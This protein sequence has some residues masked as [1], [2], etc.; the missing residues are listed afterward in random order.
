MWSG[1][2][3]AFAG[4][5]QLV[6]IIDDMGNNHSQGLAMVT[7]A[8]ALTLAFLPHTPHAQSLARQAHRLNKE[9]LLHAPMENTHAI[10]LGPGALT[11][12]LDEK[13]FKHRL[14]QAITS[15]PYLR[16]VNNHMGSALTQSPKA[17]NWV[18]EVL[19]HQQLFFVDSLTT[20]KTVARESAK[21]HSLPYLRRDVFLDNDRSFEALKQ[22]WD[23]VLK[24]AKREGQAV[25]IAH[26]YPQSSAFLQQQLPLLKAQGI[27]VVSASSML[28]DKA[29]QDFETP[30]SNHLS[31]ANRYSLR[32]LPALAA[33]IAKQKHKEN[34]EESEK[35]NLHASQR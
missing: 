33:A 22:Q 19:K 25:L 3:S 5:A 31:G 26:P 14:T 32:A 11:S 34:E 30:S 4:S 23:K 12:D 18:M 13:E 17:M 1:S 8:A 27:E 21:Q 29:W 28:L 15:T 35:K 9:V 7:Q 6:I 16:G 24:L 10:A 2:S 20:A